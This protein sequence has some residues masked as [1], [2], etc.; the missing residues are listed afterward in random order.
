VSDKRNTHTECFLVL[1]SASRG[2]PAGL[3]LWIVVSPASLPSPLCKLVVECVRFVALSV[4]W[5]LL[6]G[7]IKIVVGSK[8]A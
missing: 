1:C 6:R 5:V 3:S 2:L 7:A 4:R 8:V